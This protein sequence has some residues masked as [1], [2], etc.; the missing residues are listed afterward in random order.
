M[1]NVESRDDVATIAL[2]R[3]PAYLAAL[4]IR[5]QRFC[6]GIT[7]TDLIARTPV[8]SPQAVAFTCERRGN[9]A[10]LDDLGTSALNAFLIA[11]YN[12]K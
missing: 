9:N 4:S 8:P 1:L 11:R 2:L 12:Y 3:L 6:A 5:V 10:V 7:R